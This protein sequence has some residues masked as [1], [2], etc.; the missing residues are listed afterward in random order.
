MKFL[1]S[2]GA[3]I[4]LAGCSAMSNPGTINRL[5]ATEIRFE[6]LPQLVIETLNEDV[7]DSSIER[8]QK[9]GVYP[10]HWFEIEFENDESRAYN[11]DGSKLLRTPGGIL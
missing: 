11:P 1:L 4:L 7:S 5:T 9:W 10:Y 3:V 8:I 2:I 6:Q